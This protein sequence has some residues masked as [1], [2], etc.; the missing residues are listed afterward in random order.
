MPNLVRTYDF[1]EQCKE[2]YKKG[3]TM[4]HIA[5][6]LRDKFRRPTLSRRTVFNAIHYGVQSV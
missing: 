4:K 6:K 5:E 1:V 3:Y 2:L